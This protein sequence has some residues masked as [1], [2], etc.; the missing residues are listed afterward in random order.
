MKLSIVTP[1]HN[2]PELIGQYEAA[3][4]GADEVIIVEVMC[5]ELE[6]DFWSAYRRTLAERFAQQTVI[7]RATPFEL[8]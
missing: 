8:L 7:V 1:W 2:C 4:A 6:R 5:D 3:V